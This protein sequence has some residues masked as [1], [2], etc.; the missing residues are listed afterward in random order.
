MS[1]LCS[2]YVSISAT[3][4]TNKFKCHGRI[5]QIT[6]NSTILL[7]FHNG[8]SKHITYYFLRYYTLRVCS[9]TDCEP[10]GWG[11]GKEMHLPGAKHCLEYTVGDFAEQ[12]SE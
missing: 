7:C 3:G 6:P 5:T 4:V 1:Y 8:F 10:L 11:R 2:S 9:S 12:M